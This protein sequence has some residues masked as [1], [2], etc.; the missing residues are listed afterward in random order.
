MR[1]RWLTETYPSRARRAVLTLVP[2]AMAV[3]IL[4]G[5]SDSG[6]PTS[7]APPASPASPARSMS[8]NSR[9]VCTAVDKAMADGAAA[10]GNDL[11]NLVGKL[12]NNNAD[13]AQQ[14]RADAMAQLKTMVTNLKT[15]AQP[16]ID[17]A[18]V[19]AAKQ[20]ARNVEALANDPKL[21]AGVRTANDLSPVLQ[22]LT[23]A[24]DPL[25][26]VCN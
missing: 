11:G 23:R 4:A 2:A 10:F 17:P 25:T 1:P 15:A 24:A 13:G 16:A 9:S 5:C 26:G 7:A 19:A 21:L 20:V 18:L 22:R 6:I 8:E 3:V 14:L 12:A